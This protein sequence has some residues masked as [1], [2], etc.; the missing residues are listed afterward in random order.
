MRGSRPKRSCPRA[1]S[2]PRSASYEALR[3]EGYSGGAGH[4]A[5]A[6]ARASSVAVIRLP[7]PSFPRA[8]APG[9]AY[10]FDLEPRAR[11]ARRHRAGRK[12]GA[13][14]ALSQPR[15]LPGGLPAR[16]PGDGV[17]CARPCVRLPWR[18]TS[19]RHLR[20][21]EARGRCDLRRARAPLQPAL[22]GDVQPLPHR[23]DGLH[24]GGRV[25]EGPGREPSRQCARVGVHA[26]AALCGSG[27]A[28][29]ALDRALSRSSPASAPTRSRPDRRIIEVWDEERTVLRAM[30][31]PFDGY[32]EK[33]CRISATCLVNFERN[34]YSVE[35]RYVGQ[36]ATVRAYAERIV[37]L[38][39][40]ELIGEHARCF[41]R[42]PHNLQPLALRSGAGAQARSAAQRRA[43][44]GLEPACRHDA[45]ARAAGQAPGRGSAVR[46]DPLDGR[47]LWA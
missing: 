18:G 22:P 8:S 11:R 7:P 34:R 20:Q 27:G 44:Q 47:A 24:A 45:T 31:A 12:G 29:R 13:R 42:R 6:H 39:A 1:N 2:A 37:V 9:E 17:R 15:V 25:G 38:C 21:L 30:P 33:T 35:C 14:A 16:E 43:V 41:E 36:V 26:E 4:C 3:L 19:A 23:A 32:A 5:P 10:Q 46:G 40:G 28:E